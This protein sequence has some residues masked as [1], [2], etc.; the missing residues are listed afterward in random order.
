M[1]AIENFSSMNIFMNK[2]IVTDYIEF[3]RHFK[4]NISRIN[5]AFTFIQL[6]FRRLTLT[7]AIV[8]IP[9]L[10]LHMSDYQLGRSMPSSCSCRHFHSRNILVQVDSMEVRLQCGVPRY[11]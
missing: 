9:Y 7:K 10:V 3:K 11:S 5:T 6:I 2:K 8:R 4:V 1:E